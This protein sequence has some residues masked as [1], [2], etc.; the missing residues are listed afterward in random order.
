MSTVHFFATFSLPDGSTF[1][2]T[3]G[4][5]QD[6]GYTWAWLLLDGNNKIVAKG[7][8]RDRR[9]AESAARQGLKEV[10]VALFAE[11]IKGG[12]A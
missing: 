6:Y 11:V 8:S 12:A 3:R 5:Q 9:L 7:F 4:S 2:L 1:V 10:R